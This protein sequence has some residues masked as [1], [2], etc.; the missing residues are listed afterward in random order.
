MSHSSIVCSHSPRSERSFKFPVGKGQG[1]KLSAATS[2][3]VTA[4]VMGAKMEGRRGEKRE[5][6][7][8][9]GAPPSLFLSAQFLSLFHFPSTPSLPLFD[10]YN[11]GYN[12]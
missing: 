1:I 12:P 2:Q 4:C 8:K 7:N 3:P 10:A 9:E 6:E 5:R 11:T